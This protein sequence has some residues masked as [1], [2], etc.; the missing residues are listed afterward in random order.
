MFE[1]VCARYS[2]SIAAARV[3]LAS[4]SSVCLMESKKKFTSLLKLKFR[5]YYAVKGSDECG[6]Q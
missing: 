5:G 1:F 2:S 6:K 3:N 4:E